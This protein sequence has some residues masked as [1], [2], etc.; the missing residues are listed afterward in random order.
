MKKTILLLAITSFLSSC[1]ENEKAKSFGGIQTIYLP[2]NTK[3][4]NVTWK[5]TN[6]WYLTRKMNSSES[7]ES[8]KFHEKSS[9]GVFEGTIVIKEVKNN[10]Q[11][12]SVK[13]YPW[14]EK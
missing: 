8:Y 10:Y 7:A 4:V 14:S 3:L 12:N 9:W 2:E 1:T 5:E 13:P 11:K 6:L